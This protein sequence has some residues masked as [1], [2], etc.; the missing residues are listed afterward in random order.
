VCNSLLKNTLVFKDLESIWLKN[1]RI[2]FS[3]LFQILE[4]MEVL[5]II[6][7]I[8]IYYYLYY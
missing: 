3:I 1:K 6:I 5:I 7:H 4:L 8:F 2:L